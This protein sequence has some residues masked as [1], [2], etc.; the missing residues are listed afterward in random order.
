MFHKKKLNFWRLAI[1]FIG[2]TVT[3]LLL[4]WNSPTI[5]KPAM[6]NGTMGDTMRGMHTSN[7]TIYDLLGNSEVKQQVAEKEEHHAKS[8][9]YAI[10]VWTT[11]VIFLLM[12]F[13]LGGSVILAII[14]MK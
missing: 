1:L 14:W 12:P 11:G 3:I 5:P 8:P 13:I 6:M 2:F 9:V 7:I 4:L 10:G